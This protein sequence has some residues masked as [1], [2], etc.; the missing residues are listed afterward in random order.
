MLL[1]K[2]QKATSISEFV[3]SRIQTKI[4]PSKVL[5]NFLVKLDNNCVK[6]DRGE[7]VYQSFESWKWVYLISLLLREE[8]VEQASLCI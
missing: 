6:V 5:S 2:T 3:T 4:K 8:V 1:C 7:E